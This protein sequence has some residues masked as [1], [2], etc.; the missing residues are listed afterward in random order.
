MKNTI[1]DYVLRSVE[2]KIAQW[3]QI[4]PENGEYFHYL[5]YQIGQEYKPH[6]D[7]FDPEHIKQINLTMN[8]GKSLY[9]S[10]LKTYDCS[11]GVSWR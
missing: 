8:Q 10:T 3:I 9:F 11:N 4:P 5:K 2:N 7:T 1:D 6:H